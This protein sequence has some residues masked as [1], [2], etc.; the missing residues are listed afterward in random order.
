[1]LFLSQDP[2]SYNA[3]PLTCPVNP[4]INQS[5]GSAVVGS[6]VGA[7]WHIVTSRPVSAYDILPYGGA[8]S[9]LPSAE[10]ILPTSA[11]GTNYIAVDP[12]DSS[13]PPWGQ[14]TAF[15]DNTQVQIMPNQALP[16]AGSVPAAPPAQTTTFVL[17]A[18]QYV[19]WQTGADMTGS[20]IQSD[21]PVVFTGGNAYIC[22]SSQTSSG[23][24]CDSAHQI[25]PP[26]SALGFEY[27]APPYKGRGG[28]PE[29]IRYRIVAAVDGT[30]LT[31]DPPIP[32][33]PVSLNALQLGD[34]ETTSAF[35]VTSGG[36]EFPFYLAQIMPGCMVPNNPGD[37]GD[38]EWVNILPPIQFLSKYVFFTDPTYPNT[39][40]ALVRAST[41]TGFKD[42]TIDCLG[43]VPSWVPVGVGGKYEVATIDLMIGGVGQG[44]GC[45]NGPHVATSE[46]PFG[47]VV[48]GLDWFSSYGY[49][50]GGNVATVN[51]VI[52]PPIPE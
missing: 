23:G 33:A 37:V 21:K 14:L 45:T 8:T 32:G 36:E 12:P 27:V 52:V 48:W 15:Q 24:G 51:Q 49:P 30:T 7:A 11:W 9:Y 4:A 42:V 28:S 5:G 40:F 18:G 20:V 41:A 6:N 47:L 19:Q 29:S 38:E 25:I 50:A 13:G 17:N 34:F 26:V 31:Y 39:N 2:Q 10:L 44:N 22:Y 43:V 1:V 46:G 16:A 3:N 35:S